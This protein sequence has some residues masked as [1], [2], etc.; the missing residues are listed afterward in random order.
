[1]LQKCYSSKIYLEVKQNSDLRFYRLRKINSQ[2]YMQY[3]GPQINQD[4]SKEKEQN[5]QLQII[6]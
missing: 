2:I 1:M 3:K 4:N 5:T 6:L